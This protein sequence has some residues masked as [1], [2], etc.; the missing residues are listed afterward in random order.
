MTSKNLANNRFFN[1]ERKTMLLALCDL[2]EL[3]H[4]LTELRTAPAIIDR[5]GFGL[6]KRVS[7]A[8]KA[9]IEINGELVFCSGKL[10]PYMEVHWLGDNAP[11]VDM[12]RIS[13]HNHISDIYCSPNLDI[14]S[15]DVA[16]PEGVLIRE[17][18]TPEH[19]I[20][21]VK[22]F[23]EGKFLTTEGK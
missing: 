21:Y 23:A 5:S 15:F 20:R 17:D 18:C 16:T 9:D 10:N 19:L 11:Q 4:K 6:Y 7:E 13:S 2:A 14:N 12:V 22:V 3:Q 1:D 8:L